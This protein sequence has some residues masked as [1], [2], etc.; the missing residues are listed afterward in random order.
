MHVLKKALAKEEGVGHFFLDE[1]HTGGHSL[2]NQSQTKRSIEVECTTLEK[3]MVENQIDSIDFLKMDCEGAE[4]EILLSAPQEVIDKIDKISMEF[5]PTLSP[6][7][8]SRLSHY[9]KK[10]GYNVV[11]NDPFMLYAWR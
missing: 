9:L 7:S 11:D 4:G 10:Q 6:I 8:K 1:S 5:H 3:V 2:Y